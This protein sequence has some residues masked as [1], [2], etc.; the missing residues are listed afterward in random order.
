MKQLAFIALCA[1]VLAGC[2]ARSGLRPDDISPRDIPVE[3]FVLV[4]VDEANSRVAAAVA[5][6]EEWPFDALAVAESLVGS[7]GGRYASIERVDAPAEVPNATTITFIAGGYL[8]DSVWGDWNQV[9]L[10]RMAD[11]TWRIDEARRAWNCY[12]G[13]QTESFGERWCL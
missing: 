7:P 9:L 6:G 8:D 1:L 10:S 2:T 12:R 11:G 13:H 5:A 3:S 4:E